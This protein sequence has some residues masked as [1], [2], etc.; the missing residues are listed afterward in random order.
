MFQS[1]CGWFVRLW[2]RL[3]SLRRSDILFV[4][5]RQSNDGTLLS[6]SSGKPR[7]CQEHSILRITMFKNVRR[8]RFLKILA[9]TGS[10]T[11]AVAL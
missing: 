6:C 9:D 4:L 5:R 1:R 10:A 11:A 2:I 3:S 7:A 8:E